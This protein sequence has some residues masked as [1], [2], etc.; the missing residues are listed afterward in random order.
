M[1][2]SIGLYLVCFVLTGKAGEGAENPE[3]MRTTDSWITQFGQCIL[4]PVA[5]LELVWVKDYHCDA[6]LV[7]ARSPDGFPMFIE[8]RDFDDHQG[9][10]KFVW[11]KFT[12]VKSQQMASIR[13]RAIGLVESKLYKI[14][15]LKMMASSVPAELASLYEYGISK[16]FGEFDYVMHY[17]DCIPVFCTTLT[18]LALGDDIGKDKA[19]MLK[20]R[21]GRPIPLNASELITVLLDEG[22]ITLQPIPPPQAVPKDDEQATGVIGGFKRARKEDYII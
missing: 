13:T 8:D 4:G 1:S 9:K 20:T 17:P 6:L 15:M 11:Y 10:Y 3:E 5:H 18:I 19:D 16:L 12:K 2:S 7:T 14:S 21:K 22:V